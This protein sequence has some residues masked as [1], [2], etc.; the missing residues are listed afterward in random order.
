MRTHGRSRV[1]RGTWGGTTQ[2]FARGGGLGSGHARPEFVDLV[3]LVYFLDSD[4]PDEQEVG[5]F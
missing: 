2:D 5:V 4:T 3:D 1:R